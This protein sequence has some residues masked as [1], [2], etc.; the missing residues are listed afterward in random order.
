MLWLWLPA[1]IEQIRGMRTASRVLAFPASAE[2][3]RLLAMRAAFGLPYG[4]LLAYTPDPL[5]DL[6]AG[7]YE[8]LVRAAFEDVGLTAPAS[9]RR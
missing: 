5:G 6:A 1:R 4:R 3:Q 8:A 9:P 2:R 7:R